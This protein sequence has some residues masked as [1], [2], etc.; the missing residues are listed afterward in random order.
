MAVGAAAGCASPPSPPPCATATNATAPATATAA[1]APSTSHSLLRTGAGACAG[2]ATDCPAVSPI[3]VACPDTAGPCAAWL[4]R[5]SDGA[6]TGGGSCVPRTDASAG[7]GPIVAA[8]GTASARRTC[9]A[10]C[11]PP[12][13]HGASAAASSATSA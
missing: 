5:R 13:S 2:I 10:A 6:T 11:T 4:P 9:A 3:V 12:S 7:R 8:T 1:T